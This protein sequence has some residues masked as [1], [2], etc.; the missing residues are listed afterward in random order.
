MKRVGASKTMPG[1][2][3]SEMSPLGSRLRSPLASKR[4]VAWL[5]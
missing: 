3:S 5:K 1:V 4:G 2:S